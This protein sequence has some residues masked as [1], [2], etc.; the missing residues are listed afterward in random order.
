MVQLIQVDIGFGDAVYPEPE[1]ESFPVL[2][3]ME[4]PVIRAYPREAVIAEKL[5]ADAHWDF[6]LDLLQPTEQAN[7]PSGMQKGGGSW[8]KND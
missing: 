4:P 7:I 5:N 1:F 3:P 6:K 8:P 2:L